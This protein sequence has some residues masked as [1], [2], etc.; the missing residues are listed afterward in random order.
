MGLTL[1]D[2]SIATS[3]QT[4]DGLIGVLEKGRAH[5]EENN[6]GLDEI[7]ASTLIEG[8]HGFGFQV[9]CSVH[10]SVGSIEGVM[11]GEFRPPQ[12]PFDLDYD[13]LE[14]LVAEARSALAGYDAET[15]NARTG[16]TVEFVLGE[17]RIPF[18]AE[19]FVLSFSH[20]NLFF[21]ATTTYDLLRMRGVPLGKRDFMGPLRIAG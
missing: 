14:Q 15:V 9:L 19:N 2:I 18:T 3:L 4:I 5:C 6:I 21:H 7:A 17:R 12:G 13:A 11:S 8:M 1:H 20:P 16:A 10:H